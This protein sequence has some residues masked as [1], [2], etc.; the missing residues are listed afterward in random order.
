MILLPAIVI[1]GLGLPF[2]GFAIAVGSMFV[3]GRTGLRLAALVNVLLLIAMFVW[4][5]DLID[6][7]N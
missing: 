2:A 4:G 7:L 6:A 3:G 1:S 5:I